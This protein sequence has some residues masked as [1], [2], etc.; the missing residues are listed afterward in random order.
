MTTHSASPPQL[1]FMR[2]AKSSW[3]DETL[4]DHDRPLNQRGQKAA[5]K[6]AGFL[7]DKGLVPSLI[8]TSSARRAVQTSHP[9]E[10]E[11]GLA[12]IVLPQLYHAS[13]LTWISEIAALRCEGRTILIGHNP[14]LEELVFHIS[15]EEMHL[16]TGSLVCC[17]S[18]VDQPFWSADHLKI[19]AIWR[20]REL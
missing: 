4:P 20:P 9:I 3:D 16:P 13:L 7:R 12:A 17:R 6:M 15:G 2:H 8:V 5:R 1:L 18:T 19:E 14:G 11:F 10:A